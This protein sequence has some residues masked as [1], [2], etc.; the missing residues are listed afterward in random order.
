[1][2]YD[3]I[4]EVLLSECLTFRVNLNLLWIFLLERH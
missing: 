2:L 1:M 4:L 3:R